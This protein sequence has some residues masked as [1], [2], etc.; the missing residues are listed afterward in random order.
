MS[1][2]GEAISPVWSFTTGSAV[3]TSP[4]D[5]GRVKDLFR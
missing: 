1:F 3:A 4:V 5:W 2:C